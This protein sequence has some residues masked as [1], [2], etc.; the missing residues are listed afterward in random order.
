MLP[1][2]SSYAW[3]T[4]A[5]RGKAVAYLSITSIRFESRLKYLERSD[6]A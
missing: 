4:Q 5:V 6:P 3:G 2:P 1:L